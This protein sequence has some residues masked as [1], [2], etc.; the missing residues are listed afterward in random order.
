MGSKPCTFKMYR[1]TRAFSFKCALWRKRDYDDDDVRCCIPL[2]TT[3]KKHIE[4]RLFK[5][6]SGT[7]NGKDRKEE[8]ENLNCIMQVGGWSIEW[9]EV[10]MEE[11][12]KV[13]CKLSNKVLFL[14]IQN[15][16]IY[17]Y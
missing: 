14:E 9:I 4:N 13:K 6:Q 15:I 10:N 1:K 11:N 12:K 2:G 7:Q 3:Y 5:M 8:E 17:A 16:H